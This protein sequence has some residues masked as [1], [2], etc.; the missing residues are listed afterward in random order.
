MQQSI[1]QD[2]D[3]HIPGQGADTKLGVTIFLFGDVGTWKTSFA[4]TF[5]KPLFFSVGPEGGDD[6]LAMLPELYGVKAPLS[7]HI[8]SQDM[9]RK[10]V[11]V[12]CREY[13]DMDINTVVIDS[14]TYYVDLWIAELMEFRYKDPKIRKKMEN[15][16]VNSTIMTM[17][18]WGLLAMHIRDLAMR[19]HK[20]E[21]NVIWTALEKPIKENDENM[22][23]SRIIAVEPYVRGE[24]FIK[25]PG[26]C[27][28]IIHAQKEMK[29]MTNA[30][31]RMFIQPVYYTAPNYLTK[32][33]RHK[34]GNRFPEGKLVQPDPQYGDIPSF[35]AIYSKIGEFIYM[36]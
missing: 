36:T 3:L 24:T 28:M 10:K 30:P 16:G 7:Y 17:R 12:V 13:K 31:G 14:V 1:V 26:M 29:P 15:Q 23:T 34:Y 21:L 33:V 4:G 5:P 9:M 19:L 6:A 32:M 18:D 35:G 2:P 20:T 11:E 8:T 22:G 25:L 27:K